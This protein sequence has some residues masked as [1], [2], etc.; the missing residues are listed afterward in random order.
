MYFEVYTKKQLLQA[1]EIIKE[2]SM[3]KT[4]TDRMQELITSLPVKDRGLAEKFIAERR[5]QDLHDLVKSDVI[6]YGRL[7]EEERLN[8]VDINEEG[9]NSLLAEVISYLNI[10]GWD[11]EVINDC[12]EEP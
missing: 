3:A 9:M 12:D 7:S 11:E 5:F 6:K 8:A 10:I 4:A 2:Y 1:I